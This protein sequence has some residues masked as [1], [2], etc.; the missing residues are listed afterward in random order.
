MTTIPT[1][2]S[3]FAESCRVARRAQKQCDEL[4]QEHLARLIVPLKK[5]PRLRR[6]SESSEPS[7]MATPTPH[8]IGRI[9]GRVTKSLSDNGFSSVGPILSALKTDSIP[10]AIATFES[11]LKV[12]TAANF[13]SIAAHITW[14]LAF[15]TSSAGLPEPGLR[16]GVHCLCPTYSRFLS[17][18]TKHFVLAHIYGLGAAQITISNPVLNP[19]DIAVGFESSSSSPSDDVRIVFTARALTHQPLVVEK[20]TLCV[21]HS[22]GQIFDCVIL[23]KIE[24]PT[25]GKLRHAAS[26]PIYRSGTLKFEKIVIQIAQCE[27]HVRTFRELRHAVTSILPFDAECS[28][29]V[30]KQDFGVVEVPFPLCIHCEKIPQGSESFTVSVKIESDSEIVR[31]VDTEAP[32]LWTETIEAPGAALDRTL[33]L[34]A[35]QNS[36]IAVQIV[37]SLCY[38]KVTRM[39]DETFNLHFFSPFTVTFRLFNAARL[40][41]SLKKVPEIDSG[42]Q[43]VLI[44]VFEYHLPLGCT[45]HELNA[46]PSGS[47]TF[48]EVPFAVPLA[49]S[50]QEA[51]SAACFLRTE[52]SAE[53]FPLGRYEL[54]Y[55]LGDAGDTLA[56]AVEMPTVTIARKKCTAIVTGPETVVLNSPSVLSI[57]VQGFV[58]GQ[59]EC[60]LIIGES[61]S[62]RLQCESRRPV[63]VPQNG[64]VNL[65]VPFI[66]IVPGNQTFPTLTIA[67]G[68]AQLWTSFLPIVV[69][70]E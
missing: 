43:Y 7:A 13:H 54:R 2:T 51:F 42:E 11:F 53:A 33:Q 29:S 39:Q 14:I 26:I 41:V 66:P 25:I 45:I 21:E 69:K 63:V 24:L 62:F 20:V 18:E 35:A 70:S 36:E 58:E 50:P 48:Q 52:F 31:L 59:L 19:L 56:F 44:A 12:F 57:A 30:V 5:F 49:I 15:L 16:Y 28:F 27:L 32:T 8:A 65:E 3:S 47:A 37:W 67:E 9:V 6:L 40:P 55:S 4:E 23:E 61:D 34:L 68:G 1:P 64:K 46:I 38:E 17:M 22:N 10:S 60:E